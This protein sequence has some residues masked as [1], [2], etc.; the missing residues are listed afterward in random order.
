MLGTQELLFWHQNTAFFHVRNLDIGEYAVLGYAVAQ[1]SV[2]WNSSIKRSTCAHHLSLS[3]N[4][5]KLIKI[6]QGRAYIKSHLRHSTYTNFCSFTA[7]HTEIFMCHPHIVT[8]SHPWG[9]VIPQ[10][11]LSK[12]QARRRTCKDANN[13]E[14]QT[15][16]ICPQTSAKETGG[17]SVYVIFWR[18]FWFSHVSNPTH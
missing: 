4:P 15:V 17:H 9:S 7:F 12:S 14:V 10:K 3:L 2:S 13:W 5:S 1:W 16:H 8:H 18:V 6:G 11:K